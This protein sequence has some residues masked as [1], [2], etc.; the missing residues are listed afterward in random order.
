MKSFRRFTIIKSRGENFPSFYD[1]K[2]PHQK[3]LDRCS[4][5][6]NKKIHGPKMRVGWKGRLR[7][8][9]GE[10]AVAL[11]VYGHKKVASW[12]I[13]NRRG[14]MKGVGD[15][16]FNW[17]E[18][19]FRFRWCE[20]EHR[21]PESFVYRSEVCGRLAGKGK[22]VR[23]VTSWLTPNSNVVL[24][25][26]EEQFDCNRK[27]F[28]STVDRKSSTWRNAEN[29]PASL[30]PDVVAWCSFSA[31]SMV[32]RNGKLINAELISAFSSYSPKLGSFHCLD[33]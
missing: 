3:A 28:I 23:T 30:P 5:M 29:A 11:I 25:F 9:N 15:G 17:L 21:V 2:F 10:A 16:G 31:F 24:T 32:Q 1:N 12:K 13:F 27:S 26:N 8:I 18:I 14:G 4:A 33:S 7:L 19:I 6:R 22:R 20:D